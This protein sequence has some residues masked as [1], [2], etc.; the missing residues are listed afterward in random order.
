[1][2]K[3]LFTLFLVWVPITAQAEVNC[4][5]FMPAVV[6][7]CVE[8]GVIN[9]VEGFEEASCGAGRDGLLN[10]KIQIFSVDGPTWY[11]DSPDAEVSFLNAD[12]EPITMKNTFS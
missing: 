6:L 3:A 11:G 5:G 10:D 12:G 1:M 2:L 8:G 4:L 7:S 9:K